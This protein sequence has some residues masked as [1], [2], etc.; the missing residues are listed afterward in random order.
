MGQCPEFHI[1]DKGYTNVYDLVELSRPKQGKYHK[2]IN[3]T[4]LWY[5]RIVV[6]KLSLSALFS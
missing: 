6:S 1:Y 3:R 4:L 2:P 5:D